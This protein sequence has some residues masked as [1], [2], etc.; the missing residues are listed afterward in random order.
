LNK[1]IVN[2]KVKSAEFCLS[3]VWMYL[4]SS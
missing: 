4:M 1:L 2:K 3:P